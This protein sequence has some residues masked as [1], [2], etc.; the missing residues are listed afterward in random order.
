MTAP[1]AP[2]RHLH[3]YRPDASEQPCP[4]CRGRGYFLSDGGPAPEE[5]DCDDCGGT[6]FVER[7]R[8][9]V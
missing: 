1:F 3:P 2:L 4:E 8:E 5:F 9:V 6:G 7:E